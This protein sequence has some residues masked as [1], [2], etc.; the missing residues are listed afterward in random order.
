MVLDDRQHNSI[1]QTS[2]HRS[3]I[4]RSIQ[5]FHVRQV[6][7]VQSAP[8]PSYRTARRSATDLQS[9]LRPVQPAFRM[10]LII[11][12]SLDH[13][14]STATSGRYVAPY[15]RPRCVKEMRRPCVPRLHSNGWAQE[16]KVC[17]SVMCVAKEGSSEVWI[18]GKRVSSN[19]LGIGQR[20]LV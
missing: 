8:F 15:R 12:S 20:V 7:H 14:C 3:V 6:C 17:K 2:P 18:G 19:A 10:R 13:P 16:V 9:L 4:G 11:V 1:I 5:S